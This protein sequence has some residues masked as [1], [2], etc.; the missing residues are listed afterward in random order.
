MRV[1]GIKY[2]DGKTGWTVLDENF[3][4]VQP[5]CQYLKYLN[6]LERSPNTVQNYARHLKLFWEFLNDNY[7]DWK[8]INLEKLSDFIHWLRR[9]DPKT[10]SIKKRI[11][12]LKNTR[13]W[14]S[15]R[16]CLGGL[17]GI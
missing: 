17:H 4:P 16:I 15:V 11:K 1:Q 6:N 7:L 12:A 14:I 9:P 3:Y 5:T 8:A 13:S 2:P 10:V